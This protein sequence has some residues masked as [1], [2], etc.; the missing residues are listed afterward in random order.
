MKYN[1]H[2]AEKIGLL[3][4]NDG[5]R[6]YVLSQK[7]HRLVSGGR[8]DPPTELF[9]WVVYY[10]TLKEWEV[11]TPDFATTAT[12]FKTRNDAVRHVEALYVLEG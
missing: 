12:R 7:D 9:A 2:A 5:C 6:A 3:W 4:T 1:K 11:R 10:P 8:G